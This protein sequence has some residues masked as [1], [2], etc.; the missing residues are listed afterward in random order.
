MVVNTSKEVAL[1]FVL[2]FRCEK[3]HVVC[4]CCGSSEHGSVEHP[5]AGHVKSY[6]SFIIVIYIVVDS[7]FSFDQ[8]FK[9]CFKCKYIPLF[10]IVSISDGFVIMCL[11]DSFEL[12]F[13]IWRH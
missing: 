1:F 8:S 5:K 2:Y 6:R 13:C 12:A 9:I 4:C 10:L 11:M 7:H 3:V